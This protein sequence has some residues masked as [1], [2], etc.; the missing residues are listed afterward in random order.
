[1]KIDRFV[2]KSC[3]GK[4]SITLKLDR[5]IT[6]DFV[7]LLVS[8]GFSELSNFT[9]SGI[10]YVENDYIIATGAFGTDKLQIRCKKS[11]CQEN[12]NNFEDILNS[13]V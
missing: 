2:T 6:I 9:K 13:I 1:M 11:D 10:L 5:P 12:I 8:N 3:C 7:T 4:S